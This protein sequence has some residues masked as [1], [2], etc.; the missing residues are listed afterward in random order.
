[1]SYANNTLNVLDQ[2]HNSQA[3]W[4]LNEPPLTQLPRATLVTVV[5]LAHVCGLIGIVNFFVLSAARRH[6]AEQP[7]VQEKIVGALLTPLLVGDVMHLAIT[8]W[9]LGDSKWNV[10][11]WTSLLWT[12][13]LVGLALFIPRVAWYAGYGRYV[14]ERDGRLKQS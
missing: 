2:T 1:M 11:S 7:A 6:L 12:T 10:A 3:P 9:A 5:Q 13:V 14:H 4:P 8:I